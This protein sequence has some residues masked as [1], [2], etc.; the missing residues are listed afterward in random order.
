MIAYGST[1]NTDITTWDEI[2]L[3]QKQTVHTT[4]PV[5]T[6]TETATQS[7][8]TPTTTQITTVITTVTPPPQSQTQVFMSLPVIVAGALALLVAVLAILVVTTRRK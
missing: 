7:V 4:V 2:S 3:I 1:F 8:I 5:T 6:L